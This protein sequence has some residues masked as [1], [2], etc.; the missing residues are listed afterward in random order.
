[1]VSWKPFCTRGRSR[2]HHQC[3]E[4]LALIDPLVRGE[5]MEASQ[6]LRQHLNTARI[7]KVGEGHQ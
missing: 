3:E 5:R 2:L 4:H 1:M 7:T 6:F